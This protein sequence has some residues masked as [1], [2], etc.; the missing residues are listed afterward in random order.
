MC[1]VEGLVTSQTM[2]SRLDKSDQ[3]AAPLKE[4]EAITLTHTYC[5][6]S[7]ISASIASSS[8][9]LLFSYILSF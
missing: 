3:S 2:R 8:L 7:T 4:V 5:S 1:S 9:L 6:T